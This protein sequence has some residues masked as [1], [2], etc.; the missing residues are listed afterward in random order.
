MLACTYIADGVHY[1]QFAY[2]TLYARRSTTLFRPLL[3]RMSILDNIGTY[4]MMH[5]LHIELVSAGSQ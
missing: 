3:S 4:C 2:A 5:E 1:E